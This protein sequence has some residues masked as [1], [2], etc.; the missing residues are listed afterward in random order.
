[1]CKLVC[2]VALV[3]AV[4]GGRGDLFVFGFFGLAMF[5]C[6]CMMHVCLC[7]CLQWLLTPGSVFCS[8]RALWAFSADSLAQYVRNAHPVMWRER[9][10]EGK[11]ERI[12]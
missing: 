1:M 10:R 11:K 8:C 9:E 3:K 6:A 5:V 2:I 12:K 4:F 7:V